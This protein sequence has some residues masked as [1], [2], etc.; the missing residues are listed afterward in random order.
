MISL[1]ISFTF[2]DRFLSCG[3]S[4]R[5]NEPRQNH[6]ANAH[7]LDRSDKEFLEVRHC[8][9]Q[10]GS[11]GGRPRFYSPLHPIW[12]E[13]LLGDGRFYQA[14]PSRLLKEDNPVS[15][16]R[17]HRYNTTP[18]ATRTPTIYLWSFQ[19]AVDS[20][21]SDLIVSYPAHPARARSFELIADIIASVTR[22]SLHADWVI[23]KD[24]QSKI[25][26]TGSAKRDG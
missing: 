12:Q 4:T 20:K 15:I 16:K 23:P 2:F 10:D 26:F 3:L 24:P 19:L 9:H 14:D 18:C 6:I 21:H 8:R 13:Q 7:T 25:H 11:H 5:V 17:V 22:V 1:L